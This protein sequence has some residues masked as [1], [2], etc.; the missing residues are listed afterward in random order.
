VIARRP[1]AGN[2]G[3]AEPGLREDGLR[4]DNATASTVFASVSFDKG[5]A[6][7][8]AFFHARRTRRV[9][10]SIM[11]I[12]FT[13]AAVAVAIGLAVYAWRLARL[14]RLRSEARVS[15]L[16]AAI[17]GTSAESAGLP[18]RLGGVPAGHATMFSRDSDSA[19]Q[20]RPLLKVA[21]GF[22]MAVFI[23]VVIAMTGDRHERPSAEIAADAPSQESLELL[24]MRHERQG[25]NLMVTGLVR[26]PGA[27]APGVI[28]AV[29]LAFDR[30]GSFLASGRAPLEF[31]TIAAGDESPFRV[32]IPG[33]KDV[34]R[35][36]VSFRTD[37]GVVRH[38]DRRESKPG[39]VSAERPI[40]TRQRYLAAAN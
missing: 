39:L 30:D 20:G 24:S 15:A 25:E 18:E 26:N 13:V 32:T 10:G 38:V 4:F 36:R 11:L 28:I 23:I 19:V 9:L 34:G 16:A 14:E 12:G 27:P 1:R 22:G 40:S 7:G 37:S 35:C 33:V 5:R 31:A 2:R 8:A 6:R 29:V 17:D 21:V 3:R